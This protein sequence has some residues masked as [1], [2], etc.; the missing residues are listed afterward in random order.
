[1]KESVLILGAGGHAKS[2]LDTLFHIKNVNI[3]G[4]IDMH[5]AKRGKSLLGVPVLGGED[6]IFEKYSPKK[7]KL[8][9]ALG[10][11]DDTTKREHLFIK[12]KKAGFNFLSITHPFAYIGKEVS[13]GEGVQVMA[14]AVIQ[15]GSTIGDNVII[16]TK[17]SID[18]DCHISHHV[19]IAP[20]ATCCGYVRVEDGVHIGCGAIIL[21]RIHI[22]ARSLIAAGACVIRDVEPNS[23]VIGVPAK[24]T[25]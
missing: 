20:G 25:E 1:M 5:E 6:L 4:L 15:P 23:K 22:G 16:N 7:I 24:R 13:L 12:F 19:H 3:V 14:G 18:H 11:T 9:N 8:I 2:V 21:Q 10:S 17:A